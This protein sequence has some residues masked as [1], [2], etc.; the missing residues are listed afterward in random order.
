MSDD[1]SSVESREFLKNGPTAGGRSRSKAKGAVELKSDNCFVFEKDSEVH[2]QEK[3]P[4]IA[5]IIPTS[6]YPGAHN[7]EL[8]KVQ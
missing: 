7:P 1:E 6:E 5:A 4:L 8:P 3:F 2:C